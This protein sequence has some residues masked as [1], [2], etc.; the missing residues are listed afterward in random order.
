VNVYLRILQYVRPYL[1]RLIFG[2][3][4]I[5]IV[6]GTNLYVP[7]IIKSV[8]DEVLS[9]KDLTMLN[10]IALGILIM[11]VIR[12]LFFFG[13]N[14]LLSYVGQKVVVD[15]RQGLFRHLQS[16][17]LSYYETR[18]TGAIMSYVTNDVG[19]MQQTVSKELI[20]L[21]TE[22][23]ILIGSLG[24]IFYIHWKLALVT[25][26]TMPLV[27]Q[28]ISIF[29]KK[30]RKAGGVTQQRAAD[31][32][33]VLQVTISAVRVIKS[34]SREDYEVERF[35][36]EN[37]KN[38]S[39]Q[40]KAAQYSATLSPIIEFLAAVGV[41]VIIWYGG[42]EVINGNLTS[43]ALIA[44]LIYVVNLSNPIRRL[45]NVY[46][47]IQ[48]SIAAA[49]RVF[50]VFDTQPEIRELPNAL[51][52]PRIE[53]QVELQ[54]ID[55]AYQSGGLV[56]SDLS[57]VAKPGEMV[58]IVG[59]SGAGK[60]T[61]ANLIPRFY[62]PVGGSILID[63]IDIRTV[64]LSSL[65]QQ[66]GVVP[67]ETT[68]FNGTVYENILYGDLDA[69]REAVYA[70]AA[71]ANAHN[72]ITAMPE[73]YDT[74]IGERGA[75]LSGGQRQRIA[76]ARAILKN[77][78]ILILDE[79]TSALDAESEKLVQEALDTLMVGRTS[80]VIAHRLSTVQRANKIIVLDH[81]RI[82]EQGT[83]AELLEQDGLY[84]QLYKINF[85]AKAEG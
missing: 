41:T 54:A 56:L 6:A 13:Q 45:S 82:A 2:A 12:G 51:T 52:L 66:I 31:I 71:A 1:P 85:A 44:F 23:F 48:R 5:I 26:I 77:P 61:I 59:P 68:L 49:T 4:C 50:E 58:A 37:A 32:T 60:T 40:M 10:T 53:G 76:I 81:G 30:I 62:D 3:V 84:S 28:A 17:S 69:S 33:S 57:L 42:L 8:I 20:D 80:F 72:F 73:G 35:S 25:L 18:Q 9:A 55:F 39:A 14:Y 11:Y 15:V 24:V 64:T 67:Q 34:F 75:K 7:W 74:H 21:F 38:F 16:L 78:R 27:A 19:A 36:R 29:G 47:N 83:H 79:A 22:G 65:R 70:A 43:G 46:A 63:G